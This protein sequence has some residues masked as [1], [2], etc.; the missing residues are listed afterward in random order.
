MSITG[1]CDY[2]GENVYW[3]SSVD[4][5]HPFVYVDSKHRY[6]ALPNVGFVMTV[7]DVV[8]KTQPILALPVISAWL[9]AH[10]ELN[11]T[12]RQSLWAWTMNAVTNVSLLHITL[13][14]SG[15]HRRRM[16]MWATWSIEQRRQALVPI[17]TGI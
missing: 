7:L 17:R 6:H 8:K 16:E 9:N 2:T 5:V 3:S 13:G 12:K 1:L 4:A 10:Q 14:L 11:F 15:T